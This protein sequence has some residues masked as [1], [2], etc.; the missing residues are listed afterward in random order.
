MCYLGTGKST[1]I[2]GLVSALVN[3]TCPSPGKKAKGAKICVGSSIPGAAKLTASSRILVCA[4]SNT[5]VDEL[6]WR[7]HKEGFGP[8]S[9]DRLYLIISAY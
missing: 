4:P 2:V 7:L 5:A 8:V 3:G 9:N 6:A 1:T